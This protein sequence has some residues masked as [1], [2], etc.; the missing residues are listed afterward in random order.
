MLKTLETLPAEL[1]SLRVIIFL[2]KFGSGVKREQCSPTPV[3][4]F[5]LCVARRERALLLQIQVLPE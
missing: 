3:R 4:Q 5:T 1:Q 2:S